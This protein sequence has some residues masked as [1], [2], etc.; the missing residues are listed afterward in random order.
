MTDK[1]SEKDILKSIFKIR[2]YFSKEKK[3]FS[4]DEVKIIIQNERDEAYQRGVT[5][6]VE[7]I[8][9]VDFI[10]SQTGIA[11]GTKKAIRNEILEIIKE[12]NENH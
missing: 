4:E 3:T 2:K 1:P 10:F 9:D 7:K 12:K 8:R 11:I 6:T 5:D